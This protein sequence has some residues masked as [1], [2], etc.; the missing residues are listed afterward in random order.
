MEHVHDEP[1]TAALEGVLEDPGGE[2]LDRLMGGP[3]EL[4]SFL[5][6]AVGIA[7][8]V[9]EVHG[10]DLVHKDIKP[11]NILVNGTTGAVKLTGF[12]IASRL[13]RERQSPGLPE[14]IAGTLA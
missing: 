12:G 7:K 2:S 6:L 10:R 11:S 1:V 3:M 8:A 5:R 4:E 13:A 9:G 14:T